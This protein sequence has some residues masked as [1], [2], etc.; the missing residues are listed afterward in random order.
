MPAYIVFI[1]D[2]TRD[3]AEI[4]AYKILADPSFEGRPV[5]RLAL[6]GSHEV[7]EGPRRSRATPGISHV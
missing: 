6:G 7:L 1:R 4:A 3:A 5:G 2:R